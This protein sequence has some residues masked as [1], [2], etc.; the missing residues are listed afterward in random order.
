[1]DMDAAGNSYVAG[2][3]S[4]GFQASAG[5]YQRCA[6]GLNQDTFVA[7]FDANGKII[8]STYVPLSQ[9]RAVAA[10]GNGSVYLATIDNAGS[11]V[12]AKLLIDDPQKSPAPCLTPLAQNAAS[13]QAGP[14][15]AGQLITL[16]GNGMAPD[17]GTVSSNGA[18]TQLA[19]AQVLFDGVPAPLLYAQSL[20]INAMVPWEIASH[21]QTQIQVKYGGASSS[22]ATIPVAA[23]QPGLFHSGYVSSQGAIQNSDGSYNSAAN[24]AARGTE[25]AL[26]GTSGGPQS[27]AGVTGGVWP[28]SPLSM[29]QLAVTATIG[30]QS[31]QVVYAGSA[32]GQS[33]GL[34]QINL[35]VPATL[36]PNPGHVV[37]VSIGG[38]P[39]PSDVPT[40]IAVK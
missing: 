25:V 20:Q 30:G 3:A 36:N 1:M 16:R 15:A 2:R 38:T 12:V 37:Q 21:T 32:P 28:L 40:T 13:F 17:Q 24:P 26:Y 4:L 22:T 18:P 11:L 10:A 8:A 34:F 35:I 29:L 7:E 31:A 33:S 19:G 9:P 5:A 39:L 27:P 14:I 6:S 23:A